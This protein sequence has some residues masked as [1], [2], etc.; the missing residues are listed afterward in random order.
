MKKEG[1]LDLV[2]DIGELTGIFDQSANLD[3]FLQSVVEMIALHMN[4]YGMI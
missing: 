1:K 4:A 3:N 2:C